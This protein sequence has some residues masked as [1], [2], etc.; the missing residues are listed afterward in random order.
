MRLPVVCISIA[1]GVA[2]FS[3]ASGVTQ[4]F[5]ITLDPARMTVRPDA[6]VR[7]T[8][9]LTNTSNHEINL[10]TESFV[11]GG[12]DARFQ[13]DCRDQAGHSVAR[14]YPLMGSIGDRPMII[15][16]PRESHTEKVEIRPACDLT[17]PGQYEI[18][19]SRGLPRDQSN[20]VISN[21]I[22]VNVTQ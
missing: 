21:T 5:S 7:L 6:P 17:N 8:V 4:L 12:V 3:A 1:F 2:A 13:Y 11:H 22:T 14:D 16:K 9:R 18:Q 20:I 15:L 19:L 10:G